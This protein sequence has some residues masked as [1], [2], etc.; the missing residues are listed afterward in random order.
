MDAIQAAGA[1][2]KIKLGLMRLPMN[3]TTRK[4]SYMTWDIKNSR[5]MA[6]KKLA[7]LLLQKN[8]LSFARDTQ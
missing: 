6:P 4:Q 1:T 7:E 3:S 2:G 5:V 8:T